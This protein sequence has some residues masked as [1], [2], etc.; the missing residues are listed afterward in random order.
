MTPNFFRIFRILL[1]NVEERGV[2]FLIKVHK[3]LLLG[4]DS[5]M[6]NI[7]VLLFYVAVVNGSW[8][9]WKNV[10]VCSAVCARGSQE[11][12]RECNN[13][14]PINGGQNCQ[15]NSSRTVPC[16]TQPCP[17]KHILDHP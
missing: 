4:A 12:H 9:M 5:S 15:G 17:G 2:Q 1:T 11:Q 14:P 6:I 3:D 13:P 7:T 16:N 8:S 10:S